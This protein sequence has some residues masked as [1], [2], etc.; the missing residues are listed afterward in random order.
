[1]SLKPTEFF[2]LAKSLN[3]SSGEIYAR[4]AVNRAYYS[5]IHRAT[6]VIPLDCFP[7]GDDVGSHERVIRAAEKLGNAVRPGR[8]AARELAR[9]LRRM[10]ESREIADYELN[11]S[12]TNAYA[13]DVI[14]RA[15]AALALCDDIERQIAI[16][17][18]QK[19]G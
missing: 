1:M 7:D 2:D 19:A 18:N 5:A 8:S 15:R 16:A 14:E 6:E 17:T 4:T 9:A 10:K 13:D 3:E 11:K 12:I